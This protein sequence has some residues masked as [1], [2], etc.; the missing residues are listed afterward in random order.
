MIYF[1]PEDFD[2]EFGGF[3]S[4]IAATKANRILAERIAPEQ[5]RPKSISLTTRYG[6]ATVAISSISGIESCDTPGDPCTMV[7]LIGGQSIEALSPSYAS[8]LAYV[9][10]CD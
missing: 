5:F 7:H 9:F 6:Q 3:G 4:Q 2:T 10:L 8:L 1:K